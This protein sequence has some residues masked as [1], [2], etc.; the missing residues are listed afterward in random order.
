MRLL[1]FLSIL[2]L[3]LG[4]AVVSA[5]DGAHAPDVQAPPPPEAEAPPPD[6]S[7]PPDDSETADEAPQ[8][9]LTAAELD[10]LVAPIALYPD[11]LLAQ[12]MMASTYPLEVI[13]ADRFLKANPELKGEALEAKLAEED[14]D[15]SVKSLVETPEVLSMMSE[16]LDWL[17]ALG[18]AVLAQQ[19]DVLDAVQRLR[20]LADDNGKLQTTPQ[21]TVTVN[22]DAGQREIVIQPASPEVVYVPYYEPQVVYGSWPYPDYPPY[23]FE[24]APGYIPGGAIASGIAF[25]VGYALGR[26]GYWDD[27][28][29]RRRHIRVYEKNVYN[30]NVTINRNV[31]NRNVYNRTDVKSVTWQHNAYHRRGVKYKNAAVQ[32][33]YANGKFKAGKSAAFKKY[34]GKGDWPKGYKP[35]SGQFSK[36][37]KFDKKGGPNFGKP[38]DFKDRDFK[39][40]PGYAGKKPG[41]NE[42]KREGK[43]GKPGYAGKKPDF[44]KPGKG[45]SGGKPQFAV[46]KPDFDKPGKAGSGGKPGY[47]GKKPDFDKPGKGGSGGK[48]HFSGKKPDF[49]KPNKGGSDGKPK[50]APKEVHKKGGDGPPKFQ[51]GD[52]K[53]QQFK[54]PKPGGKPAYAKAQKGG[55]KPQQF[56]APRGDRPKAAKAPGKKPEMKA[57][58]GGGPPKA[59]GHDKPKAAAKGGGRPKSAAKKGGGNPKSAMK[60][61]GKTQGGDK[62]RGKPKGGDKKKKKKG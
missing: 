54:G 47:A 32:H 35:G 45:G 24:P 49:D 62:G 2:I 38:K 42:F 26:G 59:K 48:P 61:G 5:E 52:G 29:W 16:E 50:G 20:A 51:K 27:F 21:Q 17:Q 3:V 36:N 28:D 4:V 40:K 14:W 6:E 44:D 37:G 39:G 23:Y 10:Q 53:P 1:A 22:R 7:E 43:G 12:V 55:G 30:R 13:E 31:Y 60:S 46:K 34:R 9:L 56:K 18:D 58:K 8:Q 15:D 19:E 11:T 41:F 33:K 25:G 57:K